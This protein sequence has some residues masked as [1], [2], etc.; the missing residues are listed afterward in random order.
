MAYYSIKK[1]GSFPCILNAANEIAVKFF[2]EKKIGFLD[3]IKI[4]KYVLY[5]SKNKK[6]K[7]ITDIYE[8]DESTRQFTT[9]YILKKNGSLH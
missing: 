6:I 8:I 3:I 7:N 4:I 2:L 5:N 9:E 1:R